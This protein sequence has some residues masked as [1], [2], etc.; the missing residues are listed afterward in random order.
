[1][2]GRQAG[3]I[4]LRIGYHNDNDDKENYGEIHIERE[5][6]LKQLQNAGFENARDFVDFVGK[7]YNAIYNGSGRS[8]R[9]SARGQRDYTMFIQLE[10]SSDGDFYDVKTAM[11]S[12]RSYLENETPLWKK[13]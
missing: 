8:L 6:R 7:N 1:M 3:K 9:I 13:P 2:I 12:R 11:V 10:P 5:G 4:R